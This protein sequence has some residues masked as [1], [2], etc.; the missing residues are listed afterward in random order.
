M[1][2]GGALEV[3][4]QQLY[5]NGRVFPLAVLKQSWMKLLFW[6][7]VVLCM[8]VLFGTILLIPLIGLLLIV[9]L[10]VRFHVAFEAA[11]IS[12]PNPVNALRLAWRLT[13]G[14]FWRAL[15]C[16][17]LFHVGI[18]ALAVPQALLPP[19]RLVIVL[20]IALVLPV[21]TNF[22]VLTYFDFLNRESRAQTTL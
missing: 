11:I 13:K 14:R 1:G 12:R 20:F 6:V 2:Y 5:E 10:Y 4:A 22:R 18:L 19:N 21:F 9:Y 8:F 17:A 16:V 15:G 3:T 7:G